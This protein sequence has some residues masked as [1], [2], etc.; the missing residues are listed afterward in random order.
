MKTTFITDTQEIDNIIQSCQSCVVSFG[1][2]EPYA[3]PMNFAY[4]NPY[5][6]MHSGPEEGHKLELL[7]K[8]PKVCVVFMSPNQKL[9]YQHPDV[10]CSYSMDAKSAVAFGAVEFVEEP[11]EKREIMDFFMKHYTD[12]PVTYGEAAMAHVKV[13]KIKIDKLTAKHF[14]QSKRKY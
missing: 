11:T 5:I 14:G 7:A 10:G 3:L 6:Y 12:H 4:R 2:D 8:N 13:W 1:C 9:V